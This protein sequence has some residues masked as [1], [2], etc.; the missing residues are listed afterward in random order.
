[1]RVTVTV[2]GDM[3]DYI[4]EEEKRTGLSQAM[5]VYN[6]ASQGLEYKKAINS[7]SVMALSLKEERKKK[8]LEEKD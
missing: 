2:K 1:M 3:E 6:L 8:M 7:L 5:L 4:L